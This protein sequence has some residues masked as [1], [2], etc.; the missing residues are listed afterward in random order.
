MTTLVQTTGAQ[1]R[2]NSYAY[3]MAS[4]SGKDE[5]LDD[6]DMIGY[7]HP[8]SKIFVAE[9]PVFGELSP[10]ELEKRWNRF[11]LVSFASSEEKA[12]SYIEG[13]K[14]EEIDIL[15]RLRVWAQGTNGIVPRKK[16][17]AI[18]DLRTAKE[19]REIDVE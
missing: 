18:K 3:I 13:I 5:K 16:V 17:I 9:V 19:G 1:E 12:A 4:Y 11:A 10:P 15:N 7:P 2:A 8:V 14:E 6:P